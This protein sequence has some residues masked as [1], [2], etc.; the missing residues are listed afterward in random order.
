MYVYGDE[1]IA[2]DLT[3]ENTAGRVGQ[4]LSLY[5]APARGGFRNVRL[6]GHQHALSIHEGSVLHFR[7]CH[8]DGGVSSPRGSSALSQP[9][10]PCRASARDSAQAQPAGLRLPYA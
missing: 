10:P 9:P 4:A 5:A 2:G 3:I 8:I 6:L 1:F 7:D